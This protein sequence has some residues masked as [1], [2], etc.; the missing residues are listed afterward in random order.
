LGDWQL[1]QVSYQVAAK[2]VSPEKA[3]RYPT[4]AA[5]WQDWK[6]AQQPH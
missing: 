1:S 6:D 2:A 4:I 3:D 5:F